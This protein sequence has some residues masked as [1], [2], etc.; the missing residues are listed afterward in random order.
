MASV[1][2]GFTKALEWQNSVPPVSSFWMKRHGF[3]PFAE[4][5]SRKSGLWML[6][7][8]WPKAN[9]RLLSSPMFPV[10]EQVPMVLGFIPLRFLLRRQAC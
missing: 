4:L 10:W 9:C 8:N 1:T 2:H 3:V 5:R 6:P 7:S